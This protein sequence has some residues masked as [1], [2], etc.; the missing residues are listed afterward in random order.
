[1]TR[2]VHILGEIA[3]V[4]ET[5]DVACRK[6]SQQGR[7]RGIASCGRDVFWLQRGE[8]RASL[9]VEWLH[10]GGRTGHEGQRDDPLSG[11]AET[12]RVRRSD[13]GNRHHGPGRLPAA[14]ILYPDGRPGL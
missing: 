1:M 7:L 8:P 5:L 3:A 12:P 14:A 2:N 6:C 13:L 4:T 11:L 10:S 9:C